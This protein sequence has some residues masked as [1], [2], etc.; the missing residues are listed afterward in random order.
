M[1][2]NAAVGLKLV[3]AR[4]RN[5]AVNAIARD[6]ETEPVFAERI[7]RARRH[8][9]FDLF[10]FAAHFFLDRFGNIPHRIL[11]FDGNLELAAWCRPV[12]FAERHWECPTGLAL[13]KKVEHALGNVDD[14]AI[15]GRPWHDMTIVDV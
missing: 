2:T 3:D 13:G 11:F 5:R 7:V 1:Q 14:N 12:L 8:A 10:A 9:G 15:V 6:A 4:R